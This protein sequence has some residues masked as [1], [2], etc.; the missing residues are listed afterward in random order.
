MGEQSLKVFL[1]VHVFAG[2]LAAFVAFPIAAL[3]T[4][5][6]RLHAAAGRTF[7]GCFVF[8]CVGGY[9]LEFENLKSTVVDV[10]GIELNVSPFYK[11]TNTIAVINTLMVNTIALYFALTGWR[12]WRRAPQ[13]E[14]GRYPIFDSILA[15][16]GLL[17]GG[18]FLATLWFAIDRGA[19]DHHTAPSFVWE[20]HAIIAAA[21]AYVFFDAG[22]DL[23]IGVA[24]RPPK[25][26]WRIHARKMIAAE[27]GLAA[28]FPYRCIPFGRV[29]ALLM[30]VAMVVPLVFGVIVAR[31]FGAMLRAERAG[32]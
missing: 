19:V 4:K 21:S 32:A 15:V 11:Q 29:G 25:A 23:W 3:A 16:A 8:L 31:R 30:L 9:F 14:V 12:V 6:S 2:F 26:W 27:M 20:G 22:K 13:S 18:T 7:V 5:G 17:A 28:A 10:F 1:Y 24:R